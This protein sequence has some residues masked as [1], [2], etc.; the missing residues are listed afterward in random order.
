MQDVDASYG[1]LQVLFGAS[2]AVPAGGRV[3]L[4]GTNGAGKST[5]LKVAS[6]L[7]PPSR[8]RVCFD[9][10]DITRLAPEDRVRLGLTQI[11]G[12]RATFPSL[13]V[14]DNLRMGAYQFLH[15]RTLVDQRLE[16]VLAVFPSL[17]TRL[18][19]PGGTLSGG[20]QQMMALGRALVAGPR[21]LMVD[22]LS[23]GLAPVVMQEILRMVDEL[24]RR[25]TTLLLV[26]QSLNVSL[27]VADHAYFMEKGEIRF[28]GATAD[29]LERGDLVRSVFLGSGR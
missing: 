27:S 14:L 19:Q 11:G 15:R 21:L 29:L 1:P 24:G 16:E 8:G 17:R 23:L 18:G 28:S 5:L 26:E 7:L 6:G 20:E 13:T 4:L 3:A 12:G 2:L 10:R 25:G 9:G 22:E